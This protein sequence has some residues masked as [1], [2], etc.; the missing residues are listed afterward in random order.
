MHKTTGEPH[1]HDGEIDDPEDELQLR[2]LQTVSCTVWTKAPVKELEEL[3]LRNRH[4]F[5]HCHDQR[6]TCT[7]QAC[8]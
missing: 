6:L 3:Q 4:S 5:R 7:Q 8:P 1:R 2:H